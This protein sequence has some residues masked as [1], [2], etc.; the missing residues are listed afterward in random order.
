[1]TPGALRGISMEKQKNWRWLARIQT[2][3]MVTAATA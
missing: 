3:S 2:N 1:M